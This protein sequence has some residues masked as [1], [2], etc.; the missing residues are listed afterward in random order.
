MDF[1]AAI[2]IIIMKPIKQNEMLIMKE[3][4]TKA[5]CKITSIL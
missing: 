2:K 3:G 1:Y 5:E 4:V